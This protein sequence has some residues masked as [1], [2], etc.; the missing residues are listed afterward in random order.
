MD[1]FCALLFA[2]FIAF[3]IK[4]YKPLFFFSKT[5]SAASVVP[6][7]LVTEFI[8]VLILTS[9]FT[10]SNEPLAVSKIRFLD[11]A[12]LNPISFAILSKTNIKLIYYKI[13][14]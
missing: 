14:Y 4:S 7:L 1:K 11:S 6:P 9:F 5:S 8:K 13:I 10:N 2:E 3:F 12:L